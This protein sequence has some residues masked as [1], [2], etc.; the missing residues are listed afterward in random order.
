MTD[1]KLQELWNKK[2]MALKYSKYGEIEQLNKQ[3]LRRIKK[4]GI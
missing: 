1:K 2:K 4:Y 3:I